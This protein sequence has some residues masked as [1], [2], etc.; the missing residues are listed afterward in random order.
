LSKDA[1]P[2]ANANLYHAPFFNIYGDGKVCMGNVNVGIDTD[3]ALEEFMERWQSYFFTS[4][5]S[6]L[7]LHTSPVKMNI[8]QLWQKLVGADD[9]FPIKTLKT[10]G[11]KLKNIIR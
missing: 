3:C 9:K 5:F 8:V 11:K 10:T 7:L 6:H 2:D 4:Y 1:R